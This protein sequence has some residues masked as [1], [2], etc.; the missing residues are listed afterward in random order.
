[1]CAGRV[2]ERARWTRQHHRRAGPNRIDRTDGTDRERMMADWTA[3]VFEN[4]YLATDATDVHAIVSV[5][6]KNAGTAGQAG[7]AAEIIIID[8]SGSM[9]Q[10]HAKIVAAR[11]AA[12][13]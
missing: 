12:S 8:V 3:E 1:R 6:C 10:P 7:D 5:A 4:E 2:G 11:Q 13:E 9:S